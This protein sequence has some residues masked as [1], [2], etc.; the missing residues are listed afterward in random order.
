MLILTRQQGESIHIGEDIEVF[1][2]F[3]G[4]TQVKLGI[5]APE[6]V[7]ILRDELLY[8]MEKDSLSPKPQG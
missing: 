2:S 8:E 1:V 7:V 3:I 4:E 6:D 5:K